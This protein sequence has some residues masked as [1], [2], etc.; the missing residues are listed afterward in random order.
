MVISLNLPEEGEETFDFLKTV[1]A[2][3]ERYYEPDSVYLVGDSTSDYDL[4]I[5]FARDNVMISVLSVVFVII[6]LLFTFMSVGLPI[7]LILVIQGSIWVNFAF[8]GIT[9]SPFS[10]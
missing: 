4:S 6:V 1:H 3:A 8:P 2:E 9:E 10:S 7:L 5:S